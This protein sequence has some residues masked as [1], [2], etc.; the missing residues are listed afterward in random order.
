MNLSWRNIWIFITHIKKS[1]NLI[2]SLLGH[3][4]YGV[5]LQPQV[6]PQ[7]QKL[8]NKVD[9]DRSGHI[10]AMELQK[11]L[12][13]GNWSKFSEEACKLMINMFDQQRKGMVNIHEFG[14]L[15]SCINQWKATFESI[16]QDRSGYI[17]EIE[18][19][20]AFQLMGYQFS[21]MFVQNL[22]SKY[23]ARKRRLTLDNFI[24]CCV[25]IQRLTNSFRCRDLTCSGQ[26]T[27][28]YE[29]FLGIALGAHNWFLLLFPFIYWI[30]WNTVTTL[31][32]PRFCKLKEDICIPYALAIT[33]LW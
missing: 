29:D 9:K 30:K 12:V 21:P 7:I 19:S 25:E 6:N 2:I 33:A 4:E 13:N 15:F 16:D 11:A 14:A 32:T 31:S 27:L 26:A 28:N 24:V 22:L 20:R 10:S 3:A 23:D 1:F 18:L 17:D 8:F 5:P